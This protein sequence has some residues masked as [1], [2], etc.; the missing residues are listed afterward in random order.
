MS[1]PITYS[2]AGVD[3]D[4]ANRA[5]AKIKELARQTF[6]ERTLSEIGSFGG[7][8]DGAF[9]RMDHPVLVAS[10]DGVG[11]KLKIAFLTGVHNTI[12][13]DLVNHCV[14]DILVQGA[15]PLFFLDYVATGKLSP[16][17]VAGVVEGIAQGCRENGCVLLGGETAEMP[18]FYADGEYDVAGF[19]VGVA[20]REKVIDGKSIAAGDI[21]LALPSVGLHT[22]GYSLARKLF[23]EV[24]GYTVNTE[25]HELGTTVGKA[26]LQ[27]HLSY[28]R[29]LDGLLDERVVK[30][31][32]H[33]TGGGL[34]DNIPR[35]LP[36]GTA[37]EIR[38]GSWPV[39]P[40]FGLLQKIG[41]VSEAEM[42]RSFNMGV[43]MVMICA[44]HD[45]EFIQSHLD[46][47]CG[48]CY[49]IGTIVLGRQ[50]VS[51]V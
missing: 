28:F 14:N 30:G 3:I 22:N 19:I 6:N 8:F 7:M 2:D 25:V 33:I 17:V 27:P 21:V 49:R 47:L 1:K 15:R 41:N 20:D 4:A 36:E 12:G 38:R 50:Q 23:F 29:A 11:T 42:Y 16:E 48:H 10:A 51:L 40:I 13:R 39:L 24:C 18:G 9:P 43:G 32:A 45:A 31:L 35:I 5:T 34:S 44:Q 46:S 26:L 37:V